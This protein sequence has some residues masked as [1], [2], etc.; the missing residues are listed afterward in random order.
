M[1]MFYQSPKINMGRIS[2]SDPLHV[3]SVLNQSVLVFLDN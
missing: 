2:H 3:F 1:Q